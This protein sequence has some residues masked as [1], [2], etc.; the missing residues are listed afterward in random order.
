MVNNWKNLNFFD[1]NGKCYN[2]DYDS[3]E[4]KWSGSIYLSEVSIGLFEV[5][6]I[7]ILEQFVNKDTNTKA[8]G[9][10][11]GIEVPTG[12]TGSTNG[13]CNWLVE[14]QT[15]DPTEIMLFQFNMNFNSGT[16]T[17]LEMEPDGPPLQIITEL[18]LNIY[19]VLCHH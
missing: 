14:W 13:V 9:F 7:F 2:F 10:P 4:D 6:Q 17:S 18:Q 5:G 12:T 8:F 1:K 16:Q 3:S 11:H 15:S 19:T